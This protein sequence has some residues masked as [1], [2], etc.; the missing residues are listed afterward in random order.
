VG[1][2]AGIDSGHHYKELLEFAGKLP[3]SDGK[4]C[5]IFSTAGVYTEKK[6]AKDHSALGEIL[7]A[8]G[9]IIIGE[10]SCKG[11]NTNSFLKYVGGLNKDCPTQED[12]HNARQFAERMK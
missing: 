5:F 12:L 11:Y 9:F 8:K 1:F 10:F 4:K 2:G 7:S 3:A 6:M